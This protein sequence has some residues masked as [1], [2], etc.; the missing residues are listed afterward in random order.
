[1]PG[2]TNYFVHVWEGRLKLSQAL[3]RLVMR[4][5]CRELR[6]L[7]PM[8]Q[9]NWHVRI[10]PL[11]AP[12][13]KLIATE[14]SMPGEISEYIQDIDDPAHV[15]TVTRNM[16]LRMRARIVFNYNMLKPAATQASLLPEVSHVQA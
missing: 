3:P 1:M 5:V 11:T 6:P 2:Q 10:I 12:A 4:V 9:G 16:A 15:R 14:V 8:L 13:A 7:R